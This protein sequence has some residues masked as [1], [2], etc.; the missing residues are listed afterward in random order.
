MQT[1]IENLVGQSATVSTTHNHPEWGGIR[2][3]TVR[4]RA[5]YLK[6][7]DDGSTT[8]Y[9]T[10]TTYTGQAV[11]IDLRN[12]KVGVLQFSRDAGVNGSKVRRPSNRKWEPCAEGCPGWVM[13]HTSGGRAIERCDECDRFEYD[14]DASVHVAQ[15]AERLRKDLSLGKLDAAALDTFLLHLS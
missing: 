7:F 11:E 9:A 14:D 15:E 6:T 3:Q 13:S 4:V 10:V 5:V 2:N 8:L 1:I 12:L